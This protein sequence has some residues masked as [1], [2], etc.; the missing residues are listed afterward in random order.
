MEG[1]GVMLTYY[2]DGTIDGAVR[3]DDDILL[4]EPL[5]RFTEHSAK[6]RG[7]GG[8]GG[9]Y[10]GLGNSVAYLASRVTNTSIPPHLQGKFDPARHVCGGDTHTA[11]LERQQQIQAERASAKLFPDGGTSPN[12]P[13]R[14]I[15]RARRS[16]VLT[17]CQA[18]V[19]VQKCNCP[20]VLVADQTFFAGPYGGSNEAITAQYMVNTLGSIDLIYRGTQ[21]GDETGIGLT[22]MD[23]QVRIIA[24]LF[25]VVPS[26]ELPL[27][28]LCG[29]FSFL[30][31][32][33]LPD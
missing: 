7:D 23:V 11:M 13:S 14:N 15:T 26:F 16:G 28:S 25:C 3:L 6:W 24:L 1:S 33:H 5:H 22:L 31:S 19:P 32:S 30:R 2:S 29:D 18:A 27:L 21:F 20:M 10:R 17:A 12:P 9:S 4:I 8:E